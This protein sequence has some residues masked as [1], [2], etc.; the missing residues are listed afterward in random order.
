MIDIWTGLDCAC[1]FLVPFVLVTLQEGEAARFRYS[2]TAGN[3]PSRAARNLN[4]EVGLKPNYPLQPV[5]I[6]APRTPFD[7]FHSELIGVVSLLFALLLSTL[8]AEGIRVLDDSY[9]SVTL[10][11][12]WPPF[13][14]V[15]D[16]FHP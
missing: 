6:D 11:Q 14:K 12:K 7:P 3:Y 5:K 10:P 13:P 2:G 8:S 16:S 4:S 9:Q 1:P 15:R